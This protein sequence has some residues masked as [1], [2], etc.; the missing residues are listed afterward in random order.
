MSLGFSQWPASITPWRVVS[1]ICFSPL[2]LSTLVFKFWGTYPP[3]VGLK[4]QVSVF[5]A[6]LHI[7]FLACRFGPFAVSKGLL[8]FIQLVS[9][10]TPSQTILFYP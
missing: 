2:K 9:A 10:Q 4:V 6:Q 5:K 1:E 8:L 3:S 7:S